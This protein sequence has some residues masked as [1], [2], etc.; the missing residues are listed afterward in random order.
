MQEKVPSQPPRCKLASKQDTPD[1][2]SSC[3][4]VLVLTLREKT[5]YCI[6]E[7]LDVNVN[8][9]YKRGELFFQYVWIYFWDLVYGQKSFRLSTIQ[10]L[11]RWINKSL[12]LPPFVR[13]LMFSL[14]LFWPLPEITT[15]KFMWH[16]MKYVVSVSGD[17]PSLSC[18]LDNP[19]H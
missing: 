9:K 19:P 7:T 1:R 18:A 11:Q 13:I 3:L 6:P 2:Y 4:P 15:F 14:F 12:W 8:A 10:Y 17:R 16:R 5:T